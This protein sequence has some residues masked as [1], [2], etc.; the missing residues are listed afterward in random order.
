[1]VFYVYALK[2]CP[3]SIKSVDLLNLYSDKMSDNPKI[4]WVDRGEEEYEKIKQLTGR[5]TFPQIFFSYTDHQDQN[6][7]V[8][9]GGC[10]DLENLIKVSEQI[11]NSNIPLSALVYMTRIIQ[12]KKV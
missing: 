6:H 1:M 8:E 3:Y 12:G 7:M 10:D 11:K 5:P 9:V 4:K 2:S